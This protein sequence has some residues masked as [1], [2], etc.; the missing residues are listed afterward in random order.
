MPSWE[1]II[2]RV[3]IPSNYYNVQAAGEQWGAVFGWLQQLHHGLTSLSQQSESWKGAGGDAFRK[4]IDGFAK[5]VQDLIDDHVKI[6][7][8]LGMLA[9]DLQ[10]AVD[11]IPVPGWMYDDVEQKQR[12][13]HETGEVYLYDSG[14]FQ[15]N[16]VKYYTNFVTSIPLVGDAWKAVEGWINDREEQAQQAYATLVTRYG[17]NYSSIPDGTPVADWRS[18]STQ[19]FHPTGGG[20]PGGLGGV[21][22]LPGGGNPHLPGGSSPHLGQPGGLH[23]PGPG[24]GEFK[25]LPHTRL[26]GVGGPGG[27]GTGPGVGLRGLG[28]GGAGG[29]LA[30]GV[31]AGLSSG[32][33]RLP[34]LGPSATPGVMGMGAGGM[35]AGTRG[36][37]RGAGRGGR[38]GV[39][40]LGAGGHGGQRGDGDERTSWL[41]EDEDVWGSN[42]DAPPGV[43]GA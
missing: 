37:G 6:K 23:P 26:E 29:G 28:P 41:Q 39:G 13:Y 11:S 10:T 30:G 14:S 38:G 21:P 43:L 34:P 42:S 25:P 35:G 7:D 12:V 20:P 33:G 18:A 8:G 40:A 1:D 32:G 9:S 24:A 4:H 22:H 36:G 16:Y 17:Q 3:T 19:D 5:A 27:L 2:N 31:G 15:H